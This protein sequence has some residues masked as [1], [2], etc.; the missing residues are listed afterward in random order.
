MGF[1]TVAGIIFAILFILM[2]FARRRYG[3]MGLALA[4]GA[5]MSSLWVGDL[6]PLVAKAGVVIVQPPLESVVA[7]GLMLVPAALLLFSGPIYHKAGT[8]VFGSL[9]FSLLAVILLLDILR[10]AVV[11]D[12]PGKLV[13]DALYQWKTMGVTF[14]LLAAVV[15]TWGVRTPKRDKELRH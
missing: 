11:I 4:A 6:T 5:M 15:D 8:R 10:S 9:L 2:F 13:Y 14:L 1:L 7:A 3:V 12:G